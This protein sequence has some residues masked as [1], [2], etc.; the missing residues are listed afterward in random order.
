MERGEAFSNGKSEPSE[1]AIAIALSGEG[2]AFLIAAPSH[3]TDAE[4][5]YSYEEEDGNLNASSFPYVAYDGQRN[6]A[7]A[8]SKDGT[9]AL[10]G[11]YL[12]R[13]G[14]RLD[15]ERRM[16]RTGEAHRTGRSRRGGIRLRRLALGVGLEGHDPRLRR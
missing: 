3:G 2:K 9:T 10:A 8:I 13:H 7:V 1:Y 14:P 11:E 6:V 5:V 15:L 12:V 16:E 4:R